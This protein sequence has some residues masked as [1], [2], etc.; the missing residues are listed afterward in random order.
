MQE[1][2]ARDKARQNNRIIIFW[3]VFMEVF[4]MNGEPENNQPINC[5]NIITPLT[6]C[7][8]K[9]GHVNIS[10]LTCSNVSK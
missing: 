8:I 6:S 3:I 5:V 1:G 4:E 10:L 2:I 9:N 7:R